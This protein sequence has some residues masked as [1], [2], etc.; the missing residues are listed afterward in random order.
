MDL[1]NTISSTYPR[2]RVE[3]DTERIVEAG[4][5]VDQVSRTLNT[6]FQPTP[7]S[8][9]HAE[10]VPK[11]ASNV[12]VGFPKSERDNLEAL[13]SIVFINTRG[14]KITL[15]DIAK[16]T[17]DFAGA[18]IYTDNRANTIHLYAELGNN[19]VVYPVLKLY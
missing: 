6:F 10:L 18:E 14:E 4:L 1:Q 9:I 17:P 8:F 11:E 5:S 19:S 16:V 12:V 2:L 13:K 3:L 7:V 15:T